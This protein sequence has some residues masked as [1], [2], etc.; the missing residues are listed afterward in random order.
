[1]NPTRIALFASGNGSN[2]LNIIKYFEGSS[3]VDVAFVLANSSKAGVVNAAQQLGVKTIVCTNDEAEN[4]DYFVSICKENQI[5]FIILAGFLRKI[6]A[7]LIQAFP[8]RIINIHP[9]L[10]PKYGGKGMYGRFVHE[11]VALN[12]EKESGITIHF[13]NEEF[14]KGRVI[15]QFSVHLGEEDTPT[16]IQSK[17]QQLEHQ[18][19][20]PVIEK[21]ILT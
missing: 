18:H 19:F 5:D 13:V 17:V 7:S 14:D 2:A 6:P 4:E 8:E 1:M 10:L 9:S 3:A 11:A 15:A 20:A 16:S 21:T 12:K